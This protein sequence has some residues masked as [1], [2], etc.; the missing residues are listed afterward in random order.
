MKVCTINTLP[1]NPDYTPGP[2]NGMLMLVSGHGQQFQLDFAS[3]IEIKAGR[4][5]AQ[6]SSQ[7]GGTTSEVCQ[8]QGTEKKNKVRNSV[9]PPDLKS[10]K[11]CKG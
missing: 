5:T 11:A 8:V 6:G 2:G 3:N 9:S 1:P 4:Q 7:V 10:C